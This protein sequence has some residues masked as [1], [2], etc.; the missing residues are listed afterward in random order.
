MAVRPL[1]EHV[2]HYHPTK[3]K[4]IET[5]STMLDGQQP[6]DVLIENV[7]R[8]SGVS[9]GSLYHHFEDFP[10]LVEQTLVLRFTDGVDETI[11]MM[12]EALTTS[13]DAEDFWRHMENLVAF[14]QAPERAS[15]RAERARV[16]G[17]AGGNERFARRL[18]AEQDRL[19]SEIAEVVSTAQQRGWAR[20]ELSAQAIALFIQAY[21]L[22]RALDD[23]AQKKVQA[24]EWG[25]L[26]HFVNASLRG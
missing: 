7:L 2:E 20:R 6:L 19:T 8:E 3:R 25:S 11:H 16:V 24:A 15:R 14:A 23:V 17:M 10:D 9:K 26:I 13:D 5:V 18:G 1:P 21:T 4:L 12:R 22:G